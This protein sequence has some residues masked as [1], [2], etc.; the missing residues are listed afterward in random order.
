VEGYEGGLLFIVFGLFLLYT[1]KANK[2]K[3]TKIVFFRTLLPFSKQI[4]N[5][6]SKNT[7]NKKKK[8]YI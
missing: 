1:K 4:E 6:N 5:K 8:D 7:Q 2:I 3:H